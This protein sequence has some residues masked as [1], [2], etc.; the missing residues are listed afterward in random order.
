[1]IRQLPLIR[2]D[3]PLGNQRF[4]P[5]KPDSAFVVTS[6]TVV[7]RSHRN[8]L[9]RLLEAS[10]LARVLWETSPSTQSTAPP[11]IAVSTFE[12]FLPPNFPT[13]SSVG[14]GL[15]DGA[16]TT[17]EFCLTSAPQ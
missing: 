3:L 1:M 17:E 13:N 4:H 12:I 7:E 5:A 14:L 16:I 15:E 8:H 9:R 2:A 11:S 6:F 10:P